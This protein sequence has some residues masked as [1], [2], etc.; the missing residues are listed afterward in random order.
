MRGVF[1]VSRLRGLRLPFCVL[2][3]ALGFV[4]PADAGAGDVASLSALKAAYALHFVN[5]VRWEQPHSKLRFCVF[6]ESESG[7][8]MLGT[9][10]NRVVHGQTI[11]TRPMRRDSVR[12]RRCDVVFIPNS[13]AIHAPALLTYYRN[14]ATLTISDIPGFVADG[15]V[16]GFV[17]VGDRLRFDINQGAADRKRL[18]VSAKLLEL[19]REVVNQ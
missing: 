7:D 12:E 17:V 15:G 9:L 11:R 1:R 18:S 13:Y 8:R 6:G 3:C 14:S 19:A 16:I 2:C 5:L 4:A 10:H